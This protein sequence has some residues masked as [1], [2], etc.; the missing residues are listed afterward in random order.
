MMAEININGRTFKCDALPATEGFR[1]MGRT[2]KIGG[3]VI[4]LLAAISES[5]GGQ[6]VSV[7]AGATD[8]L[9]TFDVES[10]IK[11]LSDLAKTCMVDG[12]PVVVDA[13]VQDMGE[14]I[15]VAAWAADIQ[16][17]PFLRGGALARAGSRFQTISANL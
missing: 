12:A 15:E 7:L 3:P 2:L 10:A 6:D 11:L 4:G 17:G 9:A 1:L 8:M 16:F 13:N 14:L 5:D